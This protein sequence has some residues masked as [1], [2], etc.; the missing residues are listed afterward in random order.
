MTDFINGSAYYS[1]LQYSVTGGTEK[2]ALALVTIDSPQIVLAF[3]P[4]F[5]LAEYATSPFKNKAA[6][7]QVAEIEESEDHKG[8]KSEVVSQATPLSF[9]VEVAHAVVMVLAS[10]ER[11]AQAIQLN[12]RNIVV[13]QQVRARFC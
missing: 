11:N 13:A 3:D 6:P 2:S 5:A 7:A 4:L 12:I 8:D 1:M 9:R 10:D